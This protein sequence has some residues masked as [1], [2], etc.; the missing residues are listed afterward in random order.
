[1]NLPAEI[2]SAAT[3]A[4]EAPEHLSRFVTLVNAPFA[5]QS[6]EAG[7]LVEG[8]CLLEHTKLD[9]CAPFEDDNREENSVLVI[10]EN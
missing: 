9:S 10:A 6:K 2:V 8:G 3:T 4:Y 1:M 7:T 5:D